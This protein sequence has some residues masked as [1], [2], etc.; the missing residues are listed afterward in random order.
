MSWN[1]TVWVFLEYWGLDDF[2]KRLG[3]RHERW[4]AKQLSQS[5]A[6]LNFATCYAHPKRFCPSPADNRR[7]PAVENQFRHPSR[8]NWAYI[9]HPNHFRSLLVIV[10]HQSLV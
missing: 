2:P 7:P 9:L 3:L 6:V 1:S 5:M 10:L 4:M 8:G